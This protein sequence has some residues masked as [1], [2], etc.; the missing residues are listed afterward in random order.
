M[1]ERVLYV[2]SMGLCLLL[3]MALERAVAGAVDKAGARQPS[4]LA[5]VA[6]VAAV[7]LIV[8]YAVRTYRRN[9]DWETPDKS[10]IASL[11]AGHVCHATWH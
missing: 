2:P 6:K 5:K 7:V 10:L 8:L 3:G 1:A 4:R 9:Q 11:K